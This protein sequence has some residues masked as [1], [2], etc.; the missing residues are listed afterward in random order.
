MEKIVI[1]GS[2]GAGK[3]TFALELGK[4]CKS[5]VFHLDRLFWDHAWKRKS[6]DARIDTLS[7]I[8]LEKQWIIEGTYLS[9][10]EPRLEEADTIIFLDMCPLLCLQGIIARHWK[11]RG[12]PCYDLPKGSTD[13]LTLSRIWKVLTFPFTDR[14]K[15]IQILNKYESKQIIRLTSRRKV[16]EFV[17][18]E[19]KQAPQESS[20]NIGRFQPSF[21]L[22]K[23]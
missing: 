5:K 21:S 22:A 6:R 15:L 18:K 10:S 8:V 4:T 2:P 20:S 1:I 17:L 3:T 14:K 13:K 23:T 11:R 16:E 12:K 9:S 7:K 19:Q